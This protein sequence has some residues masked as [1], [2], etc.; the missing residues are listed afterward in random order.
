MINLKWLRNNK[1]SFVESM[2]ARNLNINVDEILSLDLEMRNS[3]DLA[4]NLRH[5]KNEK[6]KQI[7]QIVPK[8]GKEFSY[9]PINNICFL[10][11]GFI[12]NILFIDII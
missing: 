2:K 7:S 12:L 8:S 1:E 6:A 11:K 5:A 9:L 10:C 4:N 3:E